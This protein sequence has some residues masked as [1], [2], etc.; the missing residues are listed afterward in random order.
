MKFSLSKEVL[1][2]AEI[3]E[4]SSAV[5]R[6]VIVLGVGAEVVAGLFA[7]ASLLHAIRWW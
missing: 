1:Q 6:L 3:L 2:M 4:R 5:R 7:M